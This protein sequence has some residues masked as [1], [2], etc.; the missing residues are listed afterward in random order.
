M[1]RPSEFSDTTATA[2][3]IGIITAFYGLPEAEAEA[4]TLGLVEDLAARATNDHDRGFLLGRLV[5]DLGAICSTGARILDEIAPNL[6]NAGQAWLAQLGE[7]V[8]SW[9]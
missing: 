9:G 1:P 7:R 8:A 4:A 2:T 5:V 6:P 3:A